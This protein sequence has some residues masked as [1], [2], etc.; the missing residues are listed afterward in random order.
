MANEP[1]KKRRG[2]N[3]GSNGKNSPVIGNNG[4]NITKDENAV[5]CQ[6]A[7]DIFKSPKVNLDN[8]EEVEQAISNYFNSCL[9]RGL[10]P[11]NLGLYA[12]LGLS[13]QDVSNAIHGRSKKLSSPVIDL[14][15]KAKEALATYREMLGATGKLNPVTLIFWQKN[16][17]GLEDK[18]TVEVAPK[19]N[20]EPSKSLDDIAK[21]YPDDIIDCPPSAELPPI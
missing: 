19:T 14:I 7:L 4:V 18:Q 17:D 8:P 21:D 3:N 6:Y 13:K 9:E 16:Y 12:V 2:G 1:V 15:K 5:L 11:G 10:R 20:V